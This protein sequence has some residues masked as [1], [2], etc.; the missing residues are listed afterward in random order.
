MS[1]SPAP[2]SPSRS[3]GRARALFRDTSVYL[4]GN[5]IQKAAGF[6]LIPLYTHYLTTSQYG[7]LELA[8]TMVN[9]LLV[10]AAFGV[11]GAVNKC[12]QRDCAGDADRRSLG[13]T[14]LLFTLAT[15]S[16]LLLI[17]WSLQDI[18]A[19]LLFSGPEGPL[20]YRYMLLW[21]FFA[22]LAAIPFEL[23]RTRGRSAAFLT[24]SLIQLAIQSSVSFYLVR[25]A[26]MGIAGVLLGN[27]SGF[28]AVGLVSAFLLRGAVT[29]R[30]DS[31]LLKALTAFGAS[32]IPVFLSGWV[33]DASDRFFLQAL[34]SLSAVGIYALG[35]KFGALVNLLV[36]VPFQRA[37]TPLFFSMASEKTAPRSL[38]RVTTYFAG[39]MAVST[40][41]ISIAVPP[42]LRL[43]AAPEFFPAWRIVPLVCLAY[44]FGGLA[45][46]LGSGLV[47]SHKV[48]LIALF[49]TLSAI[50]NL[51]LNFL[52][53]P[54]LEM[55]GAALSTVI[56]FGLQLGG[57]LYALSKYYPL[58][59]EWG[60]LTGVS[61]AAL[62]PLGASFAL[63]SLPLLWDIPARI[64]LLALFPIL[65]ILMRLPQ[66][67]EMARLR[68]LLP[69][70]WMA[71][72]RPAAG[73]GPAPEDAP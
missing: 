4:V 6:I 30:W 9:L 56:A 59:L 28:L 2:D 18:L 31:R 23:L 36:S 71:R 62:L 46:C 65:I 60:R 55:Y 50:A 69:V 38:A 7:L 73:G 63:P 16:G 37:F 53:I 39:A 68:R 8:N 58:P 49:S 33:M 25:F 72:P 70:P 19:P 61:A 48:R 17:G 14:A 35:Y 51:G 13:G 32:M 66:P 11:P 54:S 57:I 24:T 15:G 44:A 40:L 26:G 29:W 41:V 21:L 34:A 42:F 47:V 20:V 27:L 3:F 67:E 64:A 45:N 52:L 5:L 22:E 12:F 10:A 43:A 1:S